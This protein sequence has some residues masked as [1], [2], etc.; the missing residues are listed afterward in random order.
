MTLS[1]ELAY[2]LELSCVEISDPA[3]QSRKVLPVF[4]DFVR[5]LACFANRPFSCS[6]ELQRIYP[7]PCESI[8]I[9]S[10]E[11]LR[12]HWTR[13]HNILRIKGDNIDALLIPQN[14]GQQFP[15][16]AMLFIVSGSENAYLSIPNRSHPNISAIP[17][18]K[19][20][21]RLLPGGRSG[22]EKIFNDTIRPKKCYIFL[23]SSPHLGHYVM[24]SLGPAAKALAII[25]AADA[26][27]SIAR[28][29]NGFLSLEHEAWLLDP[30][31][32]PSRFIEHFPTIQDLEHSARDGNH[33]FVSLYGSSVDMSLAITTQRLIKQCISLTRRATSRGSIPPNSDELVLGISLRG[34]TREAINLC[35]VVENLL[36][37]LSIRGEKVFLVIDGLAASC[38]NNISTTA[39]LSQARES[40]IAA[41]LLDA[42]VK[43]GCRGI[44]L[45]GWPL[46]D[47]LTCL[48]YC[49]VVV[50]H[51]GS[52][53]AKSMW[54]LGLKTIIHSPSP[55]IFPRPRRPELQPVGLQFRH[56]YRGDP[57]PRET[58]LP[59]ELV[60]VLPS[61]DNTREALQRRNYCLD[62][63]ASSL[64]IEHTLGSMGLLRAC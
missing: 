9:G 48:S 58:R 21:A 13:Y 47:Q 59:F 44:S 6:E 45:V 43:F 1:R 55:P 57:C 56:A 12:L 28:V 42:A 4:E 53:S 7:D 11:D 35:D 50:A 29:E 40:S 3:A 26:S 52:S 32:P 25:R 15:L 33:A 20:F 39:N 18:A 54:L 27:I 41:N 62:I 38:H 30:A 61:A 46:M 31:P 37:A 36:K 14:L 51:V 49:D 60:T 63:S 5:L 23:P 34:G 24:N 2:S 16:L 64:F 10:S 22:I 8:G 19:Q 17:L